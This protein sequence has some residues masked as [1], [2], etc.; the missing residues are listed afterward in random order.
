MKLNFSRNDFKDAFIG[1]V[2]LS[3]ILSVLYCAILLLPNQ[4]GV[5]DEWKVTLLATT[6]EHWPI[7]LGGMMVISL[8]YIGEK[9]I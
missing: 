8:F 1:M 7:F 4:F 5:H 6:K 2:I 9:K 3:I